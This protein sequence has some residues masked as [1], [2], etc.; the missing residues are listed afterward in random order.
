MSENQDVT[1]VI[2]KSLTLTGNVSV[3][4]QPVLNMNCS[5]KESGVAN[6][7]TY[8]TNQELFLAN[9]QSVSAEVIKFR[10]TATEEG[11]KLNCFV[12]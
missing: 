2:E 7:Q 5:L 9:S 3:K 4:G 6:I 10:T 8:V 1:S 12:F 11:K